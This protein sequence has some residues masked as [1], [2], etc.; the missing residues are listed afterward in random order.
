M[1]S[2][3]TRSTS[4]RK[5]AGVCGGLADYFTIDPV[6]VRLIFVVV[7]MTSGLG[8][9]AYLVFWIIVPND[10]Q[11]VPDALPRPQHHH[12]GAVSPPEHP[13]IMPAIH[14]T[15]KLERGDRPGS[16]AGQ[17]SLPSQAKPSLTSAPDAPHPLQPHQHKQ[18][19]HKFG[20]IILGIGVLVLLEHMGWVQMHILLPALLIIAGI[21]LL[22]KG[23]K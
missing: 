6:F 4:E 17:P 8:L 12:A 1:H 5:V 15:I 21:I 7:T 22:R 23:S 19:L 13:P 10:K 3:I 18:R 20:F 14:E 9:P 11:R 2:H 16:V